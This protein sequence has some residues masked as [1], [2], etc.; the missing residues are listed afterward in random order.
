MRSIFW[1]NKI[2]DF[3]NNGYYTKEQIQTFVPKFITQE[4]A[5]QITGV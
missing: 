5:N 4:E 3:Y 1:K 2:E